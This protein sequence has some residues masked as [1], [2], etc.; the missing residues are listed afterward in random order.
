[1]SERFKKRLKKWSDTDDLALL[2]YF[3]FI[4]LGGLTGVLIWIILKTN[5]LS[6]I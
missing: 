2:M 3:L 5:L 1:M 4:W 6:I